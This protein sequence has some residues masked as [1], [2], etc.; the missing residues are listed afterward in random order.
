M[1]QESM[2]LSPSS[3][4]R[5]SSGAV[6]GAVRRIPRPLLDQVSDGLR[7]VLDL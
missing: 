7:L 6:A 4:R 2:T 3:P 1:M 5:P